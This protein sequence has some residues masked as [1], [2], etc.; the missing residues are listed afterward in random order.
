MLQALA[1]LAK[2]LVQL[3]LAVGAHLLNK[4]DGAQKPT[5]IESRNNGAESVAINTAMKD[6]HVWF[7]PSTSTGSSPQEVG[8][9]D[10]ISAWMQKQNQEQQMNLMTKMTQI[11]GSR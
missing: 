3:G 6:A 1:P 10:Y 11:L 7:S 8:V 2:P 4:S 9:K 5:G